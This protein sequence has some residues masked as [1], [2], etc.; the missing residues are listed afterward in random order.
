MADSTRHNQKEG[1]VY[2]VG[3]GPGD[4]ELITLRGKRCLEMADTIL[5]DRLTHPTL[6]RLCRKDAER[7]YVGK[8]P[9]RHSMKQ[10]E[11]N[12]LMIE[13]AK[14]GRIVCRL[15]GGDPLVFGRGSEEG[16]A[17]VEAGIPFAIVPGV[18]SAIAVPAYAGIPVTHRGI[19]SSFLIAAGHTRE[20]SSEKAA[21][22]ER[23][24]DFSADTLIY[25]MGVDSL[26]E[27]VQRLIRS[28]KSPATP[29]AIIQQGTLPQQQTRTSVLGSVI[30]E[31]EREPIH[32]PAVIVI[33]EVVRLR[34]HLRWFDRRPLFGLRVVVTRSTDQADALSRHLEEAGAYAIELPLLKVR[35][36]ETNVQ[37]D[38][39]LLSH[40]HNPYQ[41]ILFCSVNAVTAVRERLRVIGRDARLFHGSSIA[42]IGSATADA[43]KELGLLA[44]YVPQRFQSEFMLDDL[45]HMCSPGSRVLFPRAKQ[46]RTLI[47]ERLRSKG[48]VVDEIT[49]YETVPDEDARQA[50]PALLA[51]RGADVITFTSSSAARFFHE[52]MTSSEI[53]SLLEGVTLACIGPTTAQTL[54][55]RG[56]HPDIVAEEQTIA[57][58]VSAL[59]SYFASRSR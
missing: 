35:F 41:W 27:I 22:N 54:R 23:S 53:A 14:S 47:Q 31:A 30:A 33:G 45:L 43:L 55:D 17:C 11:I 18:S 34:E 49:A 29:I 2:L 10:S 28:G 13:R 25:L 24:T 26:P 19:A 3:A 37:L 12:A 59:E 1:F 57:G 44:D 6:L 40:I 4:P 16:L 9:G 21:E 42:A 32:P 51:Q 58:L 15:K 36:P 38:Q 8:E 50:I 39:S 52:L 7:I 48:V 20:E 56:L 46:G 5:Y